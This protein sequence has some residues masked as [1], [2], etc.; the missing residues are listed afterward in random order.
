MLLINCPFCGP[1]DE[2]EFECGGES[3]IVRPE[4]YTEVSE[5]KWADYLFYRDNLKG[6]SV[7]RWRHTYGCGLWFNV[8]RDNVTHEIKAVYEM[9]E[10][11]PELET[12]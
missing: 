1:R 6:V 7:E 8:A 10:P 3:H 9:T 12:S 2:N 4:P 5:G 11:K